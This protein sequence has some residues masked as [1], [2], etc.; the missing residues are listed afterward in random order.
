MDEACRTTTIRSFGPLAAGC[1]GVFDFTL[2]FEETILGLLPMLLVLLLGSFRLLALRRR[3]K[4]LPRNLHFYLKTVS[5][6]LHVALDLTLTLVIALSPSVR[7]TSASTAVSAVGI[8]CSLAFLWLAATEHV[9]SPHPSAILTLYLL[10]SIPLD[11]PRA[12]TLWFLDDSVVPA[13]F[14]TRL[15]LKAWLFA[16]EVKEKRDSLIKARHDF[17]S[18]ETAGIINRAFLWW[19]N[20][21]FLIGFRKPLVLGDLFPVDRELRFQPKDLMS[22]M[23]EDQGTI[24][25]SNIGLMVSERPVGQG[26]GAGLSIAY[27]LVYVGI[28]VV[29]VIY[30][31]NAAR[32]MT[33]LRGSLTALLYRRTICK[34]ASSSNDK[35]V[36]TL[37]SADMEKVVHG[38]AVAHELWANPTEMAVF[39]WLLVKQLHVSSVAGILVMLLCIGATLA[40]TATASGRQAV[41]FESIND[42]VTTTI[43]A[44]TSIKGVK[45][46]GNT[47]PVRER[48]SHLRD[49]E[50]A[51]S[52]SFRKLLIGVFTFT[53]TSSIMAPVFAF[54]TYSIL[55]LVRDTVPLTATVAFTSLTAFSLL[56]SAISSCINCVLA[57]VTARGSLERMQAHMSTEPSSDEYKEY[58]SGNEKRRGSLPKPGV[59]DVDTEIMQMEPDSLLDVSKENPYANMGGKPSNAAIMMSDVTATWNADLPPIISDISLSL[60]NSKLTM[61]IGPVGC[62]KTTLL[63][64]ILGE[65]PHAT[66]TTT[67]NR[68]ELGYCSQTPWLTNATARENIIGM[69]AFDAT[70]YATV[71]RACGL[72]QD[73]QQL[74]RADEAMVGSNGTTLSGGQKARIGLARLVYSRK[75]IAVLDDVCSGLDA[76][77]EQQIWNSLFGPTGLL[78]QQE[79]TVVMATNSINNLSSADHIVVLSTEGIVAWQGTY[80]DFRASDGVQAQVRDVATTNSN[81]DKYGEIA[82][83]D[84][85]ADGAV[86]PP[87][88]TTITKAIQS[89]ELYKPSDKAVYMYYAKVIGWPRWAVFAV[90][91]VVFVLGVAFPSVWI[92]WW[93][94]ETIKRGNERLA[95]YLAIYAS[96]G[97]VAVL[98][99]LCASSYFMMKIVPRSARKF[100]STLL[101]TVLNAPMAFFDVVDIGET[102]NRFSQDLQLIDT[103]LPL[104]LISTTISLISCIVQF[105]VIIIGSHYTGIIMPF[106]FVAILLVQRFYLRTSRRLR[107]LDIESRGPVLSH[108]LDFISGGPTIRAFGWAE[109]YISRANQ[110]LEECQKP[111]Y[112]LAFAQQWLNLVLDLLNA[113]MAIIVVSIA[114][115]T[116]M[117]S[118]GLTGL[119][120]LGI[121]GFGQ[122]VKSFIS[123]WTALEL[124]MGAVARIQHLET[125]AASEHLP[126]EK[127]TPPPNWPSAGHIV[128][129]A[130]EASYRSDLPPVLKGI[131]FQVFPGQRLGICGRTGSGK[132]SIVSALL[133]LINTS[134]GT[135]WIDGVDIS[136]IPRNEL[137]RR[138]I[139]LPQEPFLAH[140]TV[141]SNLDPSGAHT[142]EELV[143]TLTKFRLWN[144]SR[145][146]DGLSTELTDASFSH[147][148]RQLFCLA[149]AT[150]RTDSRILIMDESTSYVDQETDELMQHLLR[151]ALPH[152]TTI[153]I[154]H[155]IQTILDHDLVA[156][157]DNGSVVELDSP[158]AL[159]SREDCI[160]SELCRLSTAPR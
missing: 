116:N 2:L 123:T 1:N 15:V 117:Y 160:F 23:Q 147:G 97:L 82:G 39:T 149:Q 3:E 71:V 32:L 6:A 75:R 140:G 88:P 128:F 77:T 110:A 47:G 94:S 38:F 14:T 151:E 37:I 36:A 83:V 19:L 12:R 18:E 152:C 13:I 159:L 121:V 89:V 146:P 74:A 28:A 46:T 104:A 55:S 130:V 16:L 99:F 133:R 156:V 79:T 84:L 98:A 33:A 106:I 114:V 78:T 48:V 107:I 21:L 9:R 63:N 92:Q 45:L 142:D 91:C 59:S 93:T 5:W 34:T 69:C 105:V 54:G 126:A 138:L 30:Q 109:Q 4:L 112:G 120:L 108:F 145:L 127:E 67:L 26:Q 41:W 10:A 144:A 118:S 111:F 80:D 125:T 154:A 119:A 124:A 90:M 44:I 73:F 42:R 157:I 113:G 86:Q 137:R 65:V 51:Q 87:N 70:W 102:C 31:S 56:S 81:E 7:A 22:Q 11:I 58:G 150:L 85:P 122:N 64:A 66:G 148:Q 132:S 17:T 40:L 129:E 72:D 27:A 24:S 62:G 43:N 35:G 131:S 8:V 60:P 49:R 61:I 25:A 68:D 50:I 134:A 52:Q 155:K 135:I 103:E 153:S 115:N 100:H 95:F 29:G 136:T 53:Y 20:R 139:T 141:R 101:E 76:T 158:A 57:V 143:T 96:M